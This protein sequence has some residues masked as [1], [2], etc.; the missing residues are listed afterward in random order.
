M[1]GAYRV[2]CSFVNRHKL[3][4]SW[5]FEVE[6]ASVQDAIREATKVFFEGLTPK[7]RK[8]AAE[9]LQVQARPLRLS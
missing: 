1:L 7:E 4:F 3:P 9:T 6:T 2:R 5:T 8:E